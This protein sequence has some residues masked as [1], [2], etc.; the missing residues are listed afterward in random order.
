M[1]DGMARYYTNNKTC[2][3]IM[4]TKL[5][6]RFVIY[7]IRYNN[8]QPNNSQ[9]SLSEQIKTRQSKQWT[10]HQLPWNYFFIYTWNNK[11]N[12]LKV[13]VANISFLIISYT[14]LHNT[15][16]I[17]RRPAVRI[18]RVNRYP[19]TQQLLDTPHSPPLLS[20]QVTRWRSESVNNTS[21]R[22][23]EVINLM[24]I[25]RLTTTSSILVLL[26]LIYALCP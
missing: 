6:F 24:T 8:N 11:S 4:F 9:A 26:F 21:C 18:T 25:I 2:P 17:N 22:N 3:D 12:V 13:T 1:Q 19:P 20:Q 5:V 15:A 23:W 7:L 14:R 10:K 16:K